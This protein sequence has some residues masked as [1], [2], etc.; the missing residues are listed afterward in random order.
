MCWRFGGSSAG[1]SKP[2]EDVLLAGEWPG[3]KGFFSMDNGNVVG[4]MPSLDIDLSNV[5]GG[6]LMVSMMNDREHSKDVLINF[7]DA[8]IFDR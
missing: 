5:G 6:L 2:N 1:F 7:K 4:T 3:E 8:C